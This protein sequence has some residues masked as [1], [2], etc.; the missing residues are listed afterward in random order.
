MRT[1]LALALFPATLLLPGCPLACGGFDGAGDAVYRSADGQSMMVCQNGGYARSKGT[2]FSEGRW[3]DLQDNILTASVG[4]TGAQSFTMT[5]DTADSQT[6]TIDG[7]TFTHVTLDQVELD[8]AHVQCDDLA[9]R[10]WWTT[11]DYTLP[12]ETVFARPAGGFIS[13]DACE[14]ARTGGLYPTNASC[15]V[16]LRLCTNGQ[17]TMV[18]PTRIA[19]GMYNAQVGTI[20][21][22]PFDGQYSFPVQ[23]TLAK[24]G[25]LTTNN[26]NEEIVQNP[27]AVSTWHQI[28]LAKA[29]ASLPG[30]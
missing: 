27:R 25:T 10:A 17:S 24:D 23:G 20:S 15:E 3:A 16:Q 11:S 6:G 28:G 4:E 5:F 1:L 21:A 7:V 18:L 26:V 9:T 14:S 12:V 2:E 8:H 30:C 29:S 13:V 19:R 22:S